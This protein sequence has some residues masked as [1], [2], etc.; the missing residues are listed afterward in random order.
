MKKNRKIPMYRSRAI[1]MNS[2]HDLDT[3]RKEYLAR[4]LG[5]SLMRKGLLEYRIDV[6]LDHS[7]KAYA[8][9]KT[10]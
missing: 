10:E 5:L 9:F 4:E 1:H 3:A 2:I 6:G 7:I 8:R